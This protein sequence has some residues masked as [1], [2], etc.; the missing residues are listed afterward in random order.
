[1]K[2]IDWVLV[3]IAIVSLVGALGL[4]RGKLNTARLDG[5]VVGKEIPAGL[6][7][8]DTELVAVIHPECPY[9]VASTEAWNDLYDDGIKVVGVARGTEDEAAEFTQLS[10]ARFPIVRVPDSSWEQDLGF[11][12]VPYTL[13]LAEQGDI[14][15]AYMG[16]VKNPEAILGLLP[17]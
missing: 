15:S 12:G 7:P 2:R 9:C 10:G 11:K 6:V 14:A 1:M 4:Y 5:D 13:V 3:A 17:R 8:V 16:W